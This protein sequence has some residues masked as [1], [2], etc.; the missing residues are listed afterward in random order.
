[1]LRTDSDDETKQ[2]IIEIKKKQ[3]VL[4]RLKSESKKMDEIIDDDNMKQM[5]TDINVMDKKIASIRNENK[6]RRLVVKAT[7]R[8]SEVYDKLIAKLRNEDKLTDLAIQK[9]TRVGAS[10]QSEEDMNYIKC[11]YDKITKS[12]IERVKEEVELKKRQKSLERE[13]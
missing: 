12:K 2:L 9:V 7:K 10:L 6:K 3:K 4:Q 8:E 5:L 13:K 11:V 1:M